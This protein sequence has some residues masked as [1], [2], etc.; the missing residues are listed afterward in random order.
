METSSI[1][2]ISARSILCADT[3]ASFRDLLGVVELRLENN[4]STSQS[5]VGR[6]SDSPSVASGL[7]AH[8]H[9]HCLHDHRVGVPGK[10]TQVQRKHYCR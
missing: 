1:K 3:I 4:R 5:D 7:K 8:L 9:K 10:Q 2:A 6:S